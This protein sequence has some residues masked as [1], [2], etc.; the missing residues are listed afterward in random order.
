MF[1]LIK[2]A[3]NDG[4][5]KVV[6]NDGSNCI[7]EYFDSPIAVRHRVS[8]PTAAIKLK[9]LGRN[10]R[11]FTYDLIS[12][13]WRIGRVLDDDGEGVEVRLPHQ[14]DIYIPYEQVFVRWKRPIDDPV[15]FLGNFITE[16]P[17]YAEARSGFM[18]NYMHQRGATFGISALL[19]SSIELEPHQIEV[20][21][22]VLTD[23]TQRYLLADEVGLG[24]TIEAGII[25]RQTVLDDMRGHHILVLVPRELVNQW[26]EELGSRFGLFEFINISVFVISQEDRDTLREE[27]SKNISLLV[28]DEAHHLT[29]PSATESLQFVYS[30]VKDMSQRTQRLLLLSATPILRNEDGFLRMLNLLDPVVYPLNELET[31]RLKVINRQALAETVAALDPSNAL[32]LD[33]VLEDLLDRLPDDRRLTEL[34]KTLQDKLFDLPDETDQDFCAAVRQLRAHVSETYRLNR[35]IL[36]NRRSQIHGLTPNRKGVELWQVETSSMERIES[37]L[38]DWRIGATLAK[39]LM[40]EDDIYRPERFYWD[41]ICALFEDLSIFKKLCLNRKSD[42]ETGIC[43]A[44]DDEQALLSA[45]VM[46]VDSKSWMENRLDRLYRGIR[47]FPDSV[48]V[49]IFC[50]SEYNADQIFQYLKDHEVNVVRLDPDEKLE[51]DEESTWQGF[52]T[53]PEVQAIVCDRRAEEGINLQGGNKF[54]V[55]FDLPLQPNRIEQRMGRVDRYGAGHP[56]PSYVLLDCRSPLQ[57]AWFRTIDDGLRVFSR[58]ISSLQYLIEAEVGS[59]ALTLIN[60]GAEGFDEM[61]E[62]LSGASGTVAREL[63]L[64]DEQD[65]LDQLSAVPEQ[66]LEELFDADAEWKETN[67]AMT[68]WIEKTLMFQKVQLPLTTGKQLVDYPFRFN[69]C[70]PGI[71]LGQS[72]L[73]PLSGFLDEFLGSIDFN[74][75][76]SHSGRPQSYPYVSHR[77][78]AVKQRVRPLRYGAEFVESIRSFSE[79]DVRG[80]SYA[81]WRQVFGAENFKE[82][83][84]CFCFNFLIETH[85]DEAQSVLAQE[86]L[87]SN[88]LAHSALSRRGDAVFRPTFLQ[89]WLDEEGDELP[90]EFIERYL[91]PKYSREG[92][93]DYL[94]KNLDIRYLNAFKKWSPDFLENWNERCGRLRDR[95][96]IIVKSSSALLVRQ[97]NSLER[98][99]A[100]DEIRYAQLRTRIQSVGGREA[101]SEVA[102]LSLERS[103]NEAL[104]HGISNPSIKV[105]VAGVVFLTSE[106]V[107]IIESYLRDER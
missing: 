49:V 35:R 77:A 18:R 79:L 71:G 32:F 22:R 62:R 90:Q 106:P 66:E 61:R 58:S 15:G 19:S 65:S 104:H 3:K 88:A 9:S 85:L 21:R 78:T 46:S 70:P 38:E 7:V 24:K 55:H 72:T 44:F 39:A 99:M 59:L 82:I 43:A 91:T 14:Q 1:C 26:R 68:Y 27:A 11:V 75:P 5:G 13:Q 17:Q 29:S 67:D 96:K 50:A 89:I 84:A 57:M 95:A 31:F 45:I 34:T 12:E 103:L 92:N 10:T 42:I 102:Q 37:A 54:I 6:H 93:E 36:R 51:D 30:L 8:V 25:I 2:N 81:M 74:A 64:I 80:R 86:G 60:N 23:H 94:D 87:A 105:D 20:V 83:W 76:G 63:S 40:R 16:T 73:I 48:K 47:S 53:N 33:S 4:L 41:V 28:I 56:I 97:K 100:E 69:Y 107:S 52:L 101:N 98:A